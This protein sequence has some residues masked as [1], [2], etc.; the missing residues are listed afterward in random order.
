MSVVV[1]HL[2]GDAASPSIIGA[3]LDAT[4]DNWVLSMN[5]CSCWLG[6]CVLFWFIAWR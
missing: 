2:L 6:W 3:V 5:L 4:H 1:T